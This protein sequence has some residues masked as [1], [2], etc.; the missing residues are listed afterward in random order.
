MGERLFFKEISKQTKK[1]YKSW[2]WSL[3]G[4]FQIH[5]CDRF[6]LSMKVFLSDQ[7]FPGVSWIFPP[8][9]DIFMKQQSVLNSYVQ[10]RLML[11]SRMENL[12]FTVTI[13]TMIELSVLHLNLNYKLFTMF[14]C[15]MNTTY[16]LRLR[17]SCQCSIVSL[18]QLIFISMLHLIIL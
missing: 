10:T 1:N 2:T 13:V 6:T 15:H 14:W 7:Y 17:H 16:N 9:F 5:K 3:L 4:I 12:H 8:L 11:L 18:A